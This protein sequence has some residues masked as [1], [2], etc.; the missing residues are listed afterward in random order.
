MAAELSRRG[1]V[2][3]DADR[4]AGWESATG[5]EV[6][7][8]ENAED[9]WLLGHRWVWRRAL[10]ERFVGAQ[11]AGEHV[12]VCGIAMNQREMLDIFD[13][14]FLLR[15]DHSTQLGRLDTVSN[16]HRTAALR[17]QIL[18]GR[19]VFQQEMVASGARVLDGR[20]PTSIL[21]DQVLRMVSSA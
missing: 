9:D 7:Q 3:V 17:A 14:V 21:A 4:F 16:A 11:S 6:D 10:L 1:L 15:L 12:F 18:D 8:P 5:A 20:Q 2:A 19:P 13:E